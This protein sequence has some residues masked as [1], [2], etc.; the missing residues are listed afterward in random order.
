MF[1]KETGAQP[2]TLNPIWFNETLGRKKEKKSFI[3]KFLG[4]KPYRSD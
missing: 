3:D 1:S 4:T 2:V